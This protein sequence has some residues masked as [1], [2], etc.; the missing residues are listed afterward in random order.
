MLSSTEEPRPPRSRG[1]RV[2]R[3]PAAFILSGGDTKYDPR[4]EVGGSRA[5]RPAREDVMHGL[6]FTIERI[7]VPRALPLE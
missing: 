7:A 5:A 3:G 4:E 2:G 6:A 1:Q